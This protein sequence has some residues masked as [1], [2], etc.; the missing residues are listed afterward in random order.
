M[1]F[2]GKMWHC[3]DKQRVFYT[4]PSLLPPFILWPP[5]KFDIIL[6]YWGQ[7]PTRKGPWQSVLT[8]LWQYN[9]AFVL[10]TYTETKWEYA[11]F[12][13]VIKNLSRF[14]KK[15]FSWPAPPMWYMCCHPC[16]SYLIGRL[17][18]SNVNKTRCNPPQPRAEKLIITEYSVVNLQK[19]RPQNKRKSCSP[20]PTSA[21]PLKIIINYY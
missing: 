5:H 9:F 7:F 1:N 10:Q 14:L 11:S 8:K 12:L 3:K 15:M 2:D 19:W 13:G 21:M 17:P 6:R 20:R 16:C 18:C 4:P